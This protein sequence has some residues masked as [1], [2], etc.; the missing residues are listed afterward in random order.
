MA[1]PAE[2]WH[3]AAA[4]MVAA[5]RYAA[6]LAVALSAARPA[7]PSRASDTSHDESDLGADRARRFRR[8]A[9]RH[10]PARDAARPLTPT[11]LT[12]T[13]LTPAADTRPAT[14]ASAS[15]IGI[16]MRPGSPDG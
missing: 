9:A 1:V 15:G 8:P 12:P 6:D 3:L 10:R 7:E 14:P 11:P 13:P 16:V 5:R 2:R 4:S